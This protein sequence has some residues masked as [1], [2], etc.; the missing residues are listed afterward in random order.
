MP[1]PHADKRFVQ[2][3]SEARYR[4]LLDAGVEVWCYQPSML[5]AKVMTVDEAVAVVGS[6][7]F[8]QRSTSLDEFVHHV[9][10]VGRAGI[11]GCGFEQQLEAAYTALTT[12]SGPGMPNEGFLREDSLLAIILVTDEDDCSTNDV[13]MFNPSRD[14]LGPLNVRCALNPERLHPTRTGEPGWPVHADGGHVFRIFQSR[15]PAHRR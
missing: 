3:A 11:F 7:N 1:G 4:E 9:E 10:C 8:N 6:A 15:Q 2:L 5:H 13:E 14:D 12:Q